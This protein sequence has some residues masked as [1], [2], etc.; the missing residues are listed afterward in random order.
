MF[1]TDI[2]KVKAFVDASSDAFKADVGDTTY[3]ASLPTRV[4][5]QIAGA[6]RGTGSNTANGVTVAPAV[7]LANPVNLVWD[8]TAAAARHRQD[9]ILQ[10]LPQPAG[11]PRQRRPGRHRLLR[12]LPHQPAQVRADG[13]QL[14]T[15]VFRF[16]DGSTDDPALV[17]QGA[18][19]VPR[20]QRHARHADHGARD[21]SR[22][23]SAG[24]GH[25][26]RSGDR[27]EHLEQLHRRGRV[28]AT[29]DQLHRCH[30]GTGRKATPQGDNWKNNPSRM[31]CG[32][33]HNNINWATGENHP[34]VGGAR[35]DD[36]QCK[37]CHTATA[38]ATVY[39]IS[40]DP[41]GSEGRG[42]YPVNTAQ[43][44]PTPGYPSGQ[45]PAIPL[46]SSTN[47][48]AGVPKIAFEIKL[49]LGRCAKDD[50]QVP[51]PVR[52]RAGHV[53]AGRRQVSAPQHRR[54]AAALGDLR[55]A[56]GRRHDGGRLDRG[57]DRDGQAVSRPGGYGLHADRSRRQRLVHRHARS[58]RSCCPPM[59][60]WSPACSA[61]T[62][63]PSSSWIIP[64]TRRASACASRPSRC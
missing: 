8:S 50:G 54:H 15:T 18:A 7:N 49:R 19:Q 4:V 12:G 56:R 61:S 13:R 9:R 31:A 52:R 44:V 63:R 3:D 27:P 29:G 42:G 60:S 47:P 51:D 55:P 57:E 38:I 58:P 35:A 39:H 11:V 16:D 6:A 5:I 62:T 23:E 20:R 41:T 24:P 33:C 36:S 40:V 37:T 21:P 25:A 46:A 26:D 48:P 22:R 64:T 28:P 2:T 53:P 1:A 17:E 14:A 34:G 59:R 30:T 32:A 45:G 43:D 10:C